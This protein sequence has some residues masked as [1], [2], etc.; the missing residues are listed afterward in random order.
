MLFCFPLWNNAIERAQLVRIDIKLDRFSFFIY[1]T[2]IQAH[3]YLTI[4]SDRL[5][6]DLHKWF[7]WALNRIVESSLHWCLR[8]HYRLKIVAATVC[9][10]DLVSHSRK[11]CLTNFLSL[12]CSPKLIDST[13]DK[14]KIKPELEITAWDCF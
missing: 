11:Y 12:S 14:R 4:E 5:F 2:I 3:S 10:M 9:A 1:H 6:V 8:R 7:S 13:R